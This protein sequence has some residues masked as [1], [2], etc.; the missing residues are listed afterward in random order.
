[1]I[2][3]LLSILTSSS[4]LIIFKYFERNKVQNDEAII[5]NYFTA[6]ALGLIINGGYNINETI[7]A[8]W[9]PNAILLG[10]VFVLIF[11]VMALTSQRNGVAI[12]SVANKMSVLIPIVFSIVIYKD[13]VGIQKILGIALACIGLY[14]SVW[15]E[16]SNE[17]KA[18]AGVWLP[19]LLFFGSGFI[20]TLLKY[21]QEMYLTEND[22]LHFVPIIFLVAG[23]LGLVHKILKWEI[24]FKA[25]N[26]LWGVLL[27]VPNYLSVYFLVKTL[28]IK[29]FES[30]VI[31]P[32]NNMGIVAVASIASYFILKERLAAKNKI[33]ILLCIV[34]I[35]I[36][37]FS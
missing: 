36:I 20:D 24:R 18:S 14:L 1:M 4:L 19:I 23:S 35:G 6:F 32:V 31:F 11:N 5:V 2:Y 16:K 28:E 37:F 9:L 15:Q 17:L 7:Q 26:V 21:T 22:T 30:S 34:S 27:G 33:G 12:A 8:V 10:L 13:S 25:K 3:L 29:G